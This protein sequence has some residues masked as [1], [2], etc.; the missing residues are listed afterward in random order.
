MIFKNASY[1]FISNVV[2][3]LI[4]AIATIFLARYM[5]AEEYGVFGVALAFTSIALYFTDIGLTQTYIREATKEN[6][7]VELLTSSL[8]KI[9][10]LF[11]IIAGLLIFLIVSFFY[12]YNPALQ[13]TILLIAVP[14][15]LGAALQGVGIAYYQ[16]IQKMQ[17]IA[18]INTLT[19]LLI[20][21]V[22]TLSITFQFSLFT[23]SF[24]YGVVNIFTGIFAVWLVFYK[25][26]KFV[27]R[28]NWDILIGISSFLVGGMIVLLIPQLGPILLEKVSTTL[29]VGYYAASYKIPAVLYQIPGVVAVAFYPLLFQ[30][31][32]RG[33]F[34]EH[35]K[36]NVLELKIMNLLGIVMAIPFLF[37]ADFFI[38]LL[39]GSEWSTASDVLAILIITII[40]QSINYPLADSLTTLGLQ[41][42]RTKILIVALFIGIFCFL[43]FGSK[44]GSVG[45]AISAVIVELTM[46]IGF[47]F[48]NK[49]GF[50]KLVN[51]CMVNFIGFL[52]V[53]T[54]YYVVIP[55]MNPL[56]SI[57]FFPIL[58]LAIIF[59]LDRE[60]RELGL[61]KIK[62]KVHFKGGK[63]I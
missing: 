28:M 15:A 32:N 47:T 11:S 55:D 39:F 43:F 50:K 42:K 24:L 62:G 51:G 20:V 9:R 41:N 26:I 46:L 31:G 30:L 21:I 44:Y 37:N 36:K 5:G 7:D 45:A 58:F 14:G 57:M 40:F 34:E 18:I 33:D 2:I 1:L 63:K 25:N 23:L 29:E 6:A 59:I 49:K 53:I 3:R 16:L 4:T 38:N 48:F 13:W 10:L 22:I 17:F 35:Y 54:L 52:L 19:S 8:L 27:K 56:L 12:D 61:D 60:L